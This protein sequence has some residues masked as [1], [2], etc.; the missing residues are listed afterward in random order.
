MRGTLVAPLRTCKRRVA[1]LA[2][3]L[4]VLGVCLGATQAP[5]P[6]GERGDATVLTAVSH[7]ASTSVQF[8]GILTVA[9]AA[10]LALAWAIERA[11]RLRMLVPTATTL[12]RRRGPPLRT[13]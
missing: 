12:I 6:T 4:V 9:V 11:A 13:R 5:S 3:A 8:D 10:T 1:V 7:H 2:L